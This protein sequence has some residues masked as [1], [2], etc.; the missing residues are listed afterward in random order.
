MRNVALWL[1]PAVLTAGEAR[2]ARLGEMEGRPEVQ[3]QT[4]ASW[5]PGLR[6]M[7]LLDG[8]WV[9]TG[10]GSRAEIELDEGSAFRLDA[11]SLCELS[12]YTRLSTG[13][14]VTLVSLDRGVA[15]FTGEAA[16][17]D[18]LMLAVP[19]AQVTV[20]RGARVRIEAGETSSRIAVIEGAVLFSS[21]AAEIE[22]RE[23]Q[24]VRVEPANPARFFLY[25]DVPALESDKWS[26]ARDKALAAASAHL[27]GLQFGAADLDGY[28]NWIGTA[29]MGTVWKPK[30][31]AGWVPFCNGRWVWYDGL[32][33]TW[34]SAEPW[35]WLPYHYGRWALDEKQGWVWVPGSDTVFSPGDVYWLRGPKL[36]GW[37]PLAQGEQWDGTS[38]PQ[39]FLNANTTYAAFVQEMR[40]ID[41]AGF[42]P[43][44]D[45][46][47]ATAL[48]LALPSP[49]LVAARLEVKRPVLRAGSTRV[50]PY[51]AGV[52]YDAACAPGGAA[53][54][55]LSGVAEAQNAAGTVNTTVIQPPPQQPVVIVTPPP[56]PVPEYYPAPVYGGTIVVVNPPE[57]GG[58]SGRG[59]GGKGGEPPKPPVKR[60]VADGEQR[61]EAV[62]APAPP[63]RPAPPERP[64]PRAPSSRTSCLKVAL[65][66]GRRVMRSRRA[67]SVIFSL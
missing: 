52:T 4:A 45:A 19:G 67:A 36:A 3:V 27:P 62:Q 29:A 17:R 11:E 26:E 5:A 65:A 55:M 25:R 2:F 57:R 28:G 40:E 42:T 60:P 1:L 31:A 12:D 37:G 10:A 16:G 47:A 48:T 53:P 59:H 20:G 58:G 14:R 49:S 6:N 34:I 32:G 39:L 64:S 30:P 56:E 46:L 61:H 21:P 35:G 33:Y 38:R 7:V 18:P 54:P 9:R 50:M 44:K 51:M 41:P 13:Q 23:G 22:L 8:S 43:A 63:P 66:W 15:Y 24:W